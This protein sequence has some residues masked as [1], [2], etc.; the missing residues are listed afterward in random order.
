MENPKNER[1]TI[2]LEQFLRDPKNQ[3]AFGKFAE[4]YQPRIKRCCQGRGLQ[5]ADADDLTANILLKLFE[6]DVFTDFVFQTKEKFNAY[7]DTVVKNA[8]LTFLR[9]RGR[10]PD[11]WSVGNAAVQE[12][13]SQVIDEGVHDLETICEED[14]AL[15]RTIRSRVEEPLEEKTRQAFRLLA[16]EGRT[17]KEV[18][19]KLQMTEVAVWQVRSRV[20]RKLRSEFLRLHDPELGQGSTGN[21]KE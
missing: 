16:D 20:L 13:L 10:K 1:S 9:N 4:K 8:V 21:E 19:Q 11:A 14:R 12:S 7:L 17:V 15:L 18:A 6:R 3:E 2:F 5:D